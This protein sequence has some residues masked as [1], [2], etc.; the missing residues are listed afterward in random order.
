MSSGLSVVDIMN[1]P[2]VERRIMQLVMRSGSMTYPQLRDA[3]AEMP[4]EEQFD[5]DK[6]NTTLDR[7]LEERWLIRQADGSQAA[8]RASEIRKSGA[9]NANLWRELEGEDICTPP[10]LKT[11]SGGKRSLPTNV[12]NCLLDD[13]EQ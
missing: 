12:W 8:Y 1:L 2:H 4:A 7:L 11:T 10:S 5:E 13:K 9:R 3:F 6:L